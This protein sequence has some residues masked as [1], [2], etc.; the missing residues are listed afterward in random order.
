V[1]R[2]FY[3]QINQ[4]GVSKS[5]GNTNAVLVKSFSSDPSFDNTLEVK[6]NLQGGL[7]TVNFDYDW[8][9]NSQLA[10]NPNTA[11]KVGDQYRYTG[12]NIRYYQVTANYTS[13][14]TWAAE[15]GVDGAN[16][17]EIPGPTTVLVTVGLTTGQWNKIEANIAK[18]N[19]NVITVVPLKELNYAEYV[20]SDLS[21]SN[22]SSS[23]SGA[24]FA[25][26]A[27][28]TNFNIIVTT[29]G[30]GYDADDTIKILGTQVGGVTPT[31]DITITVETLA[32]VVIGNISTISWS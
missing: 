8:D 14:S 9:S 19:N 5:Y 11:Y 2:L 30:T 26:T 3:K 24:K 6:G 21:A 4:D 7:T 13:G 10:W 29:A 20:Y 16:S 15:P 27:R 1:Y 12:N 23:G 22:I 17:I 31:N 32:N 25:V 18:S 28:G